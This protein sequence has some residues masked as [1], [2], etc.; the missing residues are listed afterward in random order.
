MRAGLGHVIYSPQPRFEFIYR[1][2]PDDG[3][4]LRQLTPQPYEAQTN[5]LDLTCLLEGDREHFPSAVSVIPRLDPDQRIADKK[6]SFAATSNASQTIYTP[7][8][9]QE[10]QNNL[11]PRFRSR[12]YFVPVTFT[13]ELSETTL[14]KFR[15]GGA[16]CTEMSKPTAPS[17]N[18]AE[19]GKPLTAHHDCQ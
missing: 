8:F 10:K 2:V 18:L 12:W 11:C 5:N 3:Q 9:P 15:D 16:L 17:V 7:P 14:D 6:L 19:G 4:R 13:G 1:N